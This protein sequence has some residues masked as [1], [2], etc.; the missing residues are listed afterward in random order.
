MFNMLPKPSENLNLRPAYTRFDNLF[1]SFYICTW[2]TIGFLIASDQFIHWFM[3]PVLCCGILIGIDAVDWIRG[4]LNIFDPVGILGLL[5]VHFFFLAPLLHV[6]W[7]YWM[8]YVV[9]PPDW[10]DWLGGMAFLNLLGLFV[11]RI[12]RNIVLAHKQLQMKKT[13]WCLDR[14]R[15]FLIAGFALVITAG[16]QVWVYASYEGIL[17]YIQVYTEGTMSSAF[18]GMGG[19]FMISESFPIIALMTF[20]VYARKKETA[21]SWGVLTLVL[22]IFLSLQLLFGGL[23]GSRSNT[24]W[25]IFW[26]VGIIHFLIRPLPRKL[27]LTGLIFLITF[28]YWYGFYKGLGLNGIQTAIQDSEARLE[29]AQIRD[30]GLETTLLGD[31]GRSDVQAF[32]LYRL[33]MHG[34]EYELA[35]GRT[36]L[37]AVFKLIPSTIWT[38]RPPGKIKEG[39]EVQYGMGAYIPGIRQS[40]KVY[41]LAGESML[42]FGPIAVPFAFLVLGFVVANVKYLFTSLRPIDSR[43]ILL[44]FLVNL[45]FVILNS[46]SDNVLFFLIKT[47]F[48]PFLVITLTLKRQV[49][50]N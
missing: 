10:R 22:L 33:L 36:Y 12:S 44:P 41:G 38:E 29:L 26:A 40:A 27:V 25:G 31:L 35:W 28:M 13:A 49:V 2:V 1:I 14:Q 45:C 11:Y 21:K 24:V 4:R 39:T 34:D 8:R 7:D 23:R 6:Y 5:G 16:L 17:G 9:P 3:V 18:K 30:R 48:V 19:L 32:L 43:L 50:Q 46:D 15:Y 20:A 37:G 42:N 47:G